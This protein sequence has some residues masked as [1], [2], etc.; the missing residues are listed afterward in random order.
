MAR[1]VAYARPRS[2][3]TR[4]AGEPGHRDL[5]APP[6]ARR[7]NVGLVGRAPSARLPRP[8]PRRRAIP[9]GPGRSGPRSGPR[10]PPRARRRPARCG[11]GGWPTPGPAGRRAGPGPRAEV[12]AARHRRLGR[13][14]EGRAARR[15]RRLAPEAC[16]QPA[17]P[18][19]RRRAAHSRSAGR[20]GGPAPARVGRP[21]RRSGTRPPGGAP[22]ELEG[23]QEV[24]Q[25]GVPVGPGPGVAP[26]LELEA[27]EVEVALRGGR[28][29]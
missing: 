7:L 29:S 26:V 12:L 16:G 1:Q 25:L 14:V 22:V 28:A 4:A 11:P 18:R 15:G 17:G 3:T 10:R 13:R 23:E 27:G 8:G 5:P 21:R 24:G 9:P 20:R 2:A 6:P 19:H